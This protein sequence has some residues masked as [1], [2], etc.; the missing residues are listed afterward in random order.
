[1]TDLIAA[2]PRTVRFWGCGGAG[3]NQVRRYMT[4]VPAFPAIL[5]EQQFCF[6]DTSLSN[7][8][9]VDPA[10]VFH[11]K[12]VDG[13]PL[14]G[15]G[16]D[17][18]AV[19]EAIHAAIPQIV[20]QFEPADL[21]IFSYSLAGGSGSTSGPMLMEHLMSEGH[22]CVNLV[23]G[24]LNS[25]KWAR[26]TVSTMQGLET[27]VHRLGQAVIL[28]YSEV[29][30]TKTPEENDA[31]LLFTM[32]TL[33]ILGSGRN[34]HLDSADVAMLFN[35]PKVTHHKP[36]LAMLNV[37]AAAEMVV[38]NHKSPIAVAS[39][40]RTQ[41]DLAPAVNPD[42][43]TIGYLPDDTETYK[44][45]FFYVIDTDGL[46][47]VLGRMNTAKANHEKQ[48]KVAAQ[49]TSLLSE[50]TSANKLGLVFD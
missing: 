21:N 23:S 6:V 32:Q 30:A 48:K 34:K 46:N 50:G 44:D 13:T 43:A 36:A 2:K 17:R 27:A 19:A 18:A 22:K 26:N 14:D 49:T 7:L 3:A 35:Y 8:V 31:V 37:Y 41:K 33:S 20:L 9:G 25:L 45:S 38:A 42:Y 39:L 4:D 16:T 28:A 5:A 1:M 11:V 40:L 47:G 24:N 15:G 10:R 29:D 12:K